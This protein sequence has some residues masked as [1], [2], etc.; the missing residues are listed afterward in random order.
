MQTLSEIHKEPRSHP[1]EN[2]IHCYYSKEG[3]ISISNEKNKELVHKAA[4]HRECIESA[5][6]Y[7]MICK[8]RLSV[9]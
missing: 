4:K 6:V 7:K 8:V 2:R 5:S 9:H 1:I 3:V